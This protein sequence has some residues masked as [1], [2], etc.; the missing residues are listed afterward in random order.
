MTTSNRTN[1]E[2][3]NKASEIENLIMFLGSLVKYDRKPEPELLASIDK[4][5]SE[6]TSVIRNSQAFCEQLD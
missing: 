2:L 5:V 3:L 1:E 4:R 6:L